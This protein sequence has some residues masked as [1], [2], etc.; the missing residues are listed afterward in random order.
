MAGM[1]W[2][3]GHSH[4][5]SQCAD[6]LPTWCIVA[7]AILFCVAAVSAM[8]GVC[9]L[10]GLGS[11]G[12]PPASSEDDDDQPRWRAI[13]AL[14]VVQLAAVLVFIIAWAY[15]LFVVLNLFSRQHHALPGAELCDRHLYDPVFI[16][17]VVI[18]LVLV[19]VPLVALCTCLASG[20]CVGALSSSGGRSGGGQ[21]AEGQ[22]KK[23]DDYRG[24][25]GGT[26]AEDQRQLLEKGEEAAVEEGES[27]GDRAHLARA[28]AASESALGERRGGQG[29]AAGSLSDGVGPGQH[30]QGQRG[31]PARLGAPELLPRDAE[32]L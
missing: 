11:D 16:V 8:D 5:C 27:E 31:Q 6:G 13:T 2:L 18:G 28:A 3:R 15:G 29:S 30:V 9:G 22:R 25:E 24:G 26:D 32:T 10:R 21:G 1:V 14:A 20:L 23:Y 12:L 7:A 17:A 19:L 4:Q